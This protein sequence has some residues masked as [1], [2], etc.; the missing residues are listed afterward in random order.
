MTSMS[1][2]AI[3]KATSGL[4]FYC[5]QDETSREWED[6][7]SANLNVYQKHKLGGRMREVDAACPTC[8][9]RLMN[10]GHS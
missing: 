10:R 4:Y 5:E 9:G 6:H 7:S 8:L 3:K 2:V 1:D